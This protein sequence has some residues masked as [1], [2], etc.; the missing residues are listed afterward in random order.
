MRVLILSYPSHIYQFSAGSDTMTPDNLLDLPELHHSI[1]LHTLKQRYY[2][3]ETYSYIGDLVVSLNPYKRTIPWQDPSVIYDYLDINNT[4][5]RPHAWSVARNAYH[6][7]CKYK[8]SQSII[9]SGESGSGKTE[10]CKLMLEYLC[11][12]PN[13]PNKATCADNSGTV[14]LPSIILHSNILLEAFGNA[15]TVKNDNSSRFG[16]MTQVYIDSTGHIQSMSITPYLLEKSRILVASKDERLYHIYYQLLAGSPKNLRERLRINSID[17]FRIFRENGAVTTIDDVNDTANFNVTRNALRVLEF[18]DEDQEV[19]WTILASILHL[20]NLTVV[21]VKIDHSSEISPEDDSICEF[22]VDSLHLEISSSEFKRCLVHRKVDM[23]DEFIYRKLT[24]EKARDQIRALCKHL[25]T[26]LFHWIIQR[27]NSIAASN[28]SANSGSLSDG[29]LTCISLLD[30]FGFENFSVNSIEQLCIN[31]ANEALQ[32]HYSQF[33]FKKDLLELEREGIKPVQV[34][35]HDNQPVLDLIMGDTKSIFSIL[36]DVSNLGMERHKPQPDKDLLDA[37]TAIYKP[38]YQKAKPHTTDP[39][40]STEAPHTGKPSDY[41]E[42]GRLDDCSF[43][44][45]H[46]AGRV[47]YRVDG[48]L[49]KNADQTPAHLA[50][51]PGGAG[52]LRAVARGV[53]AG[54]VAAAFRQSLVGL[55]GALGATEPNWVRCV[56]PHPRPSPRPLPA[57]PPSRP[58]SQPRGCS[59][60]SRSAG[61]TTR[62]ATPTRPLPAATPA[63]RPPGHRPRPPRPSAGPSWPPSAP[64]PAAGVGRSRVFLQAAAH[65][66]LEQLRASRGPRLRPGSARICPGTQGQ[67]GLH[68]A[69]V[70][71]RRAQSPAHLQTA[72]ATAEIHHNLPQ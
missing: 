49:E 64:P 15:K 22:I 31:L 57:A 34:S 23:R 26:R 25:Y 11:K 44:V 36:D 12:A 2:Q 71:P 70:Q 52:P 38:D 42:R 68:S 19:I 40:S 50:N 8:K 6:K 45:R 7:A 55:V 51:L 3:D 62:T 67:G 41:F 54:T 13:Y 21:E 24:A 1:L 47:K 66:A 5:V 53:Q 69:Q 27:V 9:V 18:T 63:L 33:I 56:R 72:A 32:Q 46:Y 10:S 37:I 17:Q 61:P 60:P 20:S 39:A 14:D 58:S 30:I 59:R 16:K 65:E 48:F 28:L 4:N 43:T 35:F 29:S